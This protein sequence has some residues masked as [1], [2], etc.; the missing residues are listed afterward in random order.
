MK[1]ANECVH[2][3]HVYSAKFSPFYFIAT[4]PKVEKKE[5]PKTEVKEE[6]IIDDSDEEIKPKQTQKGWV[7][8]RPFDLLYNNINLL[9][10]QKGHSIA[11]LQR[12]SVEF[13]LRVYS[14]VYALHP[15]AT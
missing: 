15:Q 4:K 8:R 10:T 1:M 13:P 2:W 14:L 11:C 6:V 7:E 5:E 3:C 12:Q 9:I